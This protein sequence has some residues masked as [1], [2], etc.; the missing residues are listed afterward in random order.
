MNHFVE[1]YRRSP[2]HQTVGPVQT[3]PAHIPEDRL[4]FGTVL[5]T[6][7]RNILLFAGVLLAVLLVT[8]GITV[9][10]QRRYASTA[11]IVISLQPRQIA[12]KADT[13]DQLSGSSPS[14]LVDTEVKVLTSREL[15]SR[16]A[17]RLDLERDPAFNPTLRPPPNG[18]RVRL[19]RMLGLAKPEPAPT[20]ENVRRSIVDQLLGGLQVTRS[21][22]SYAV[23]I[24][25]TAPSPVDAERI[26][27]AFA[28]Q[29]IAGQVNAKMGDNRMAEEFL[30]GRLEQ[31]RR[32]AHADMQRVQQYRIAHNLLSTSGASLT[33][34]E[35][36]TYN[37]GVATAKAEAA[38]DTARLNTARRQLSAGSTGED[39]GEALGSAVVSQLR[40]RQAE[41][42]GRLAD[43]QA[44]YSDIHPDVIRAKSEL[45][46]I[47]ARID[48]EI[49]RV[50]SNLEAKSRVSSQRLSSI[51]GSLAGARSTLAQNNRAMT[52]LD[53]LQRSAGASQALYESY[54]G[55]YKEV[56]AEGGVERPNARLISPAELPQGP[57]SPN[58]KLNLMLGL[59]LGLGAGVAAAF[60]R[61]LLF[62]GFTTG[63]EVEDKLGLP[64]L[65]GIPTLQD[66]DKRAGPSESVINSPRSLFA[67]GFR[68]LRTAL[69]HG[70]QGTP[71]VIMV[72]SALPKEGK[73][74]LAICLARS[75]ALGG[76]R[77]VLLDFDRRQA[78]LS[79]QLAGDRSS[80]L[81]EL[82]DGAASLPDVLV[83]D[84]VEGLDILP[85]SPAANS[86]TDL[87][88]GDELK[89]LLGRLR[90]AYTFIVIDSAPVLPVAESRLLAG[91]A[92][93]VVFV[94]RWRHTPDHAVRAALKLLPS[95]HVNIAGVVLSRINMRK[96]VRF[97]RGDASSYFRQYQQ[98]Y[99]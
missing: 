3:P 36:S 2:E 24:T 46:D 65:A 83:P 87:F 52:D 96:Q 79:R 84:R 86:T 55:R 4:D 73:T 58:I 80:G 92:D 51:A 69:A 97:A 61:E 90:E 81:M 67:E 82:L 56:S 33:E 28:D 47:N 98:Y 75:I 59:L 18:L 1:I 95:R 7:R 66:E 30:S 35:I 15:A 71:Q 12:P 64:Y 9:M 42:S 43:L 72:S 93:S 32:Q 11:Q 88:K 74:T 31:L 68:M 20:P 40:T 62:A 85:L 44:R 76:E 14:D 49:K 60:V 70:G 57:V 17:N 94:A 34:Q 38:E 91:L 5:T 37:Q 99:S 29:Y 54:L 41:V 45:A 22:D 27:N 8:A 13:D 39:V 89:T 53:D 77:T 50:I 19:K 25:A 10:Q 78:R 16:V 26:A 48:A 63:Q 6:L 23:D 21:G